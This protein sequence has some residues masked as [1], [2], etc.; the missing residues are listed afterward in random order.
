MNGLGLHYNSTVVDAYRKENA[1]PFVEI[2]DDVIMPKE[3]DWRLKGAV[4]PIKNQGQ[5][6]SCWAFSSV[7]QLI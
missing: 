5:C 2:D 3:V 1:I 4:T 6:G 7:C